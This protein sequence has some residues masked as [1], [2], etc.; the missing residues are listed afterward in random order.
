M[1]KLWIDD[2]RQPPDDTWEWAKTGQDARA[3]L[4]VFNYDIISFDNDL[5]L[6]SDMEGYQVADWLEARVV[7]DGVVR[8]LHCLVHSMN[9]VAAQRIATT[10][11]RFVAIGVDVIPYSAWNDDVIQWINSIPKAR[12]TNETDT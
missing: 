10:L 4:E 8:P 7:C 1:N 11:R 2:E 12:K 3:E 5:G 9:P 6:A